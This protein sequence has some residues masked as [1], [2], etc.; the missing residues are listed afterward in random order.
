MMSKPEET[1]ERMEN[2]VAVCLGFCGVVLLVYLLRTNSISTTG[3]NV[4]LGIVLFAAIVIARIT[5]TPACV[6]RVWTRRFEGFVAGLA[7]RAPAKSPFPG[8]V[9]GT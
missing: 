3:F 6:I 8:F 4:G 9:C 5:V 2:V 7:L 1:G